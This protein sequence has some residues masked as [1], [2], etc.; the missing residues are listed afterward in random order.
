[1]KVGKS[2]RFRDR[3][4]IDSLRLR[5]GVGFDCSANRC[6][7][8]WIVKPIG[9]VIA[10]KAIGPPLKEVEFRVFCDPHNMADV[11]IY[12]YGRR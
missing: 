11:H 12:E 6:K 7:L 10:W 2:E 9:S 5:N 4:E 3:L 1:M 8:N